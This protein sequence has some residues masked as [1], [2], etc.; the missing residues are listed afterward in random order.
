MYCYDALKSKKHKEHIQNRK[1]IYYF[2]L[3]YFKKTG[4]VPSTR[5]ISTELDISMSSVQRHLNQ[6]EDDELLKFHG[7]GSH[8]TYELIG[9]SK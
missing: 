5:T 9:V 4:R 3:K 6:F 2:I 7:T 8:R 1:D